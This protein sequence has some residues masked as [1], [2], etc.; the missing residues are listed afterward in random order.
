MGYR[1]KQT[2]NSNEQGRQGKKDNRKDIEKKTIGIDNDAKIHIRNMQNGVI[3]YVPYNDKDNREVR[4]DKEERKHKEGTYLEKGQKLN[5]QDTSN[6]VDRED[7][8]E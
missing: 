6:T 8:K 7:S 4:Q 5:E 1:R 3:S 2:Q